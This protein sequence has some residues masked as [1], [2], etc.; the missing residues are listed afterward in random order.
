MVESVE[1]LAA[2]DLELEAV[3][4]SLVE[5]ADGDAAA[6]LVPEEAHVDPSFVR[7]ASSVFLAI[8]AV[9]IGLLLHARGIVAVRLGQPPALSVPFT[10]IAAARGLSSK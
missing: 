2:V 4:R 10:L 5:D 1:R 3:V 8:V 9:A 6:E 7:C